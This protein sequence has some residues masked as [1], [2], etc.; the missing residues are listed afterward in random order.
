MTWVVIW[1]FPHAY[2]EVH[3][4]II[5]ILGE[6]CYSPTFQDHSHPPYEFEAF[7]SHENSPFSLSNL[8]PLLVHGETCVKPWLL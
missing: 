1:M 4:C 3:T 2:W 6:N 8:I 7:L 5:K